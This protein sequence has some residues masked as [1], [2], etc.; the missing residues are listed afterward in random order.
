MP[1]TTHKKIYLLVTHSADY[2]C[3]DLVAEHLRKAGYTPVRINSDQLHTHYRLNWQFGN[4]NSG[5]SLR[6]GNKIITDKD[7]AA[8]WI[9]KLL[10]A[11]QDETIDVAY[12]AIVAGENNEIT[13]SFLLRLAAF[14]SFDPYAASEMA[15]SKP[16]QQKAAMESGLAIPASIITNSLK[17]ARAFMHEKQKKYITKLLRPTSWSMDGGENFFYT[18]FIKKSDLTAAHLALHPVQVQEFV[19]KQ[20]ELRV[21]Y[22]A[23]RCFSGKITVGEYEADW[24]I[25]GRAGQWAPYELPV[26]TVKKLQ[27]L[28]K[29]L[30]LQF[31]AIDLIRG[32]DGEYYFLEVNPVGEWG[33][34]EKYLQLPISEAIAQHLIKI[35]NHE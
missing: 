6:V 4:T 20:Y 26:R 5:F 30:G 1:G 25:P 18:T 14:P 2:Y 29:K 3:I 17:E 27:K 24:R 13:R 9:R 35:T 32:T 15:E 34:L 31:G 33:M 16:L 12:R 28:M 22:V 7:I 23:G 8:V 21:A 11:P 19:P 10:F